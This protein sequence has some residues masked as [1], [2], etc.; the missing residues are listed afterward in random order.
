VLD[1]GYHG[2]DYANFNKGDLENHVFFT[3]VSQMYMSDVTTVMDDPS[4]SGV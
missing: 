2:S 1:V 4:T 3:N